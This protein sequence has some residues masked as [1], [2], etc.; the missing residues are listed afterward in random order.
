[1]RNKFKMVIAVSCCVL[2][3]GLA[4]NMTQNNN[5]DKIQKISIQKDD[6]KTNFNIEVFG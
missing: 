4:I 1:M 3:G 6:S 2:I 5:E